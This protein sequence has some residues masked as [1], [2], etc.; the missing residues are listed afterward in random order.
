MLNCD[1]PTCLR[2][3]YHGNRCLVCW[4]QCPKT[5]FCARCREAVR[6][7]Y[8]GSGVRDIAGR[9]ELELFALEFNYCWYCHWPDPRSRSCSLCVPRRL[10]IH[11][12][13]GG[14]ARKHVRANLTRF[15]AACHAEIH[16][17]TIRLEHVLWLKKH[18]DPRGYDRRVLRA[19][20]ARSLPVARRP[21]LWP[22]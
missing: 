1:C 19:L 12:L 10:H 15:C 20:R 17:H 11:H 6:L 13:L 14:A 18:H 9:V 22:D 2:R 5:G 3:S 8:T 4:G 7:A 21:K 16:A